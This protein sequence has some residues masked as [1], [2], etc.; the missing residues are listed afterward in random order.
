MSDASLINLAEV[1]DVSL[2]ARPMLRGGLPPSVQR[3]VR[4][5]IEAHMGRTIPIGELAGVAGLSRSHFGRAFRQSAGVAPHDYLMR[6]R[7]RRAQDLLAGTELPLSE[8]AL[9]CGFAD[10]SHYSRHFRHRVGITPS[11]YR[12]LMR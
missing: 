11:R 4:Q 12:W 10:Q 7:V 3:R 6:C 1:R 5:H 8:I 2:Q 9:A